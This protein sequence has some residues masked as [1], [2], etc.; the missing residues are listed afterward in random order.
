MSNDN[1]HFLDLLQSACLIMRSD[2]LISD[3]IALAA[4]LE[5][6]ADSEQSKG[7][8]GLV[9]P[10][11]RPLLVCTCHIHWD[12]NYCDVKLVQTM[13]L[14]QELRKITEGIEAA[15]NVASQND[16]GGPKNIAGHNHNNTRTRSGSSSSSGSSTT[17]S[18]SNTQD[19]HN[20]LD[21][22]NL[23]VCG[24]FNSLPQSGVVEYIQCGTIS[25]SH[26]DFKGLSYEGYIESKKIES[27]KTADESEPIHKKSSKSAKRGQ[28]TLK[29]STEEFQHNFNLKSVYAPCTMPFT[30][31]TLDFQG[32]ID[33]VFHSVKGL[34]P[35]GLL[36]PLDPT[37]LV[38][39][40]VVG[41]PH[42][43]IPSDHLP[44]LVELEMIPAI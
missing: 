29:S 31:Y 42:P 9:T 5:T 12:P 34:R 28:E 22:V 8:R 10:R 40:N 26:P 27:E 41:A 37:W 43:C 21:K 7:L 35:L 19:Q 36:G 15:E 30:N 11:P 16:S 44:L 23:L 2:Q 18:I 4:L 38:Q 20:S 32:I 39:H 1:V 6:K 25:S 14:M 3:N 13:M 33:Y 24:D 17:Y